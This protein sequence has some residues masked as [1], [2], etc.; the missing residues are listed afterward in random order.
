MKTFLVKN[1]FYPLPMIVIAET[2]IDA[3]A[4]ADPS[5]IELKNLVVDNQHLMEQGF[6]QMH[7][8]NV[9]GVFR[10]FKDAELVK[11]TDLPF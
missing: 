3:W 5:V 6:T 10:L 8:T 4:D 11:D 7:K 2:P 9:R 1:E